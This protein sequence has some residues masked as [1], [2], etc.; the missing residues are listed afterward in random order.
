M[1]NT[2]LMADTRIICQL[3]VRD[4]KVVFDLN[5]IS[6]DPW[7]DPHPSSDPRLARHWTVFPPRPP[8]PDQLNPRQPAQP[9]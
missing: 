8:L 6:M 1:D 3:T 2:K 5:G 7:N 9:Q 4:G